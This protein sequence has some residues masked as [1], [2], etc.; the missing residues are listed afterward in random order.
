MRWIRMDFARGTD[1]LNQVAK[2]RLEQSRL[3]TGQKMLV[4]TPCTCWRRAMSMH[5]PDTLARR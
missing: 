5:V 3:Q 1:R 4:S 2:A